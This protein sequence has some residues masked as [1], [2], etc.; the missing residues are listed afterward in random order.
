LSSFYRARERGYRLCLARLPMALPGNEEIH[1]TTV[2]FACRAAHALSKRCLLLGMTYATPGADIW[3]QI[4][5]L[6]AEC[7]VAARSVALTTLY[8]DDLDQT[9]LE[10]EL[11]VTLMFQ[12]A[13]A[14][15]LLPAQHHA[16]DL[17]LRRY[18]YH[19]EMR[20]RFD[21]AAR[22]FVIESSDNW[23][24]S[25]WLPGRQRREG[26][27]FF[28]PG[29]A[30]IEILRERDRLASTRQVPHYVKES[31]IAL[32]LFRELLD[33][34]IQHWSLSPPTRRHRRSAN[35]GSILVARDLSHIHRLLGFSERARQGYSIARDAETAFAL[36]SILRS[37]D[38]LEG[39]SHAAP[40]APA[41]PAEA[42]ENLKGYEDAL[43][44]DCTMVWSRIDTSSEGLGA[45]TL[46]RGPRLTVGLLVAFRE[47]ESID[48]TLAVIRRLTRADGA[49]IRVGLSI[50]EG[51]PHPVR[52]TV[53]R[54]AGSGAA[55]LALGPA[56][57]YDAIKLVASAGTSLLVPPG[58]LAAG[59]RCKLTAQR[60]WDAIGVERPVESGLDFERASY[61]VLHA[62]KAA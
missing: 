34:L 41:S 30:G 47:P 13:P 20:D 17:P 19:F 29:F 32:P 39:A 42:L 49:R 3:M 5:R 56:L 25:R 36:D 35:E 52:V 4:G 60:R 14:G 50:I 16:L 10:R 8:T 31:G 61:S 22:P 58:V 9:S 57:Q 54:A 53:E 38:W 33:R 45:E 6:A 26:M 37:R 12:A 7:R 21:A 15:N 43:G 46:D 51:R 62:S 24:P 59:W 40:P 2:L 23:K 18:A 55:D 1:A 27:R 11:L 48:W 28:G 44:R